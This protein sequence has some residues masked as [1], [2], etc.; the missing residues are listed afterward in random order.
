MT[1]A[2]LDDDAV[3]ALLDGEA[4]A[5]EAAHAEVCEECGQRLAGFRSAA[6]RIGDAAPVD[7]VARERVIAAALEAQVLPLRPRRQGLPPW[8]VGAAAVILLALVVVPLFGDTGGD[9]DDRVASGD[10]AVQD[11]RSAEDGAAP[12]AP[13][14]APAGGAAADTALGSRAPEPVAVGHLGEVDGTNVAERVRA[15]LPPPS[16]PPAAG[17]AAGPCDEALR[18]GDTGLGNLRMTGT[19]EVDGRGATIVV[20][21]VGGSDPPALRAYVV[22]GEG[23]DVLLA[24]TF[25]ASE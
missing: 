8:L 14:A 18:A 6:A 20:Y 21:D 10:A 16:T 15:A 13:A 25:P 1:S 24:S 22:A 9:Q 23:C 7:Q 17:G 4:T 2:H 5:E 11:E 3:S 19:A 12:E